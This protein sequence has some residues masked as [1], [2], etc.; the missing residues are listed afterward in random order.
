M[1]DVVV[2]VEGILV[3]VIIILSGFKLMNWMVLVMGHA[4]IQKELV[5]HLAFPDQCVKERKKE[6]ME[7]PILRAAIISHS[8]PLLHSSMLIGQRFHFLLGLAS[9]LIQTRVFFCCGRFHSF[10][11]M[12]E[13]STELSTFLSVCTILTM[14]ATLRVAQ[15]FFFHILFVEKHINYGSNGMV[16]EK[17]RFAWTVNREAKSTCL[18]GLDN[19]DYGAYQ[20]TIQLVTNDSRLENILFPILWGLMTLR[21]DQC[22]ISPLSLKGVKDAGYEKDYYCTGGKLFL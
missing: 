22:S 21:F 1:I 11:L 15:L 4:T 19:Y 16:K 14:I 6:A 10:S 13:M 18:D 8:Q 7:I 17:P 5:F 3:L 9:F 12:L 20:W 2:V